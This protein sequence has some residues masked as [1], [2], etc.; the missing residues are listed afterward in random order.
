MSEPTNL[1]LYRAC[2]N[3]PGWANGQT[4]EIDDQSGRWDDW[5]DAGFIAPVGPPADYVAPILGV[6]DPADAEPGAGDYVVGAGDTEPTPD[7]E[8]A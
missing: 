5:I 2:I 7:P 4:F 1:R 8:T 3:L 6:P